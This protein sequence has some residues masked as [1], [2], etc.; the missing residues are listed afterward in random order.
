[1]SDNSPESRDL[2]PKIDFSRKIDRGGPG[3]PVKEPPAIPLIPIAAPESSKRDTSRIPLEKA[4]TMAGEATAS[5]ATKVGLAPRTI[6]IAPGTVS[7]VRVQNPLAA[8][9]PSEEKRK[10]SRVSLESAVELSPEAA[11]GP[12]TIRLKRPAEAAGKIVPT[13]IR[14]AS[15]SE[16]LS[17]TA[18]I[19]EPPEAAGSGGAEASTVTQKKTIKVKRPVTRTTIRAAVQKEQPA[20]ISPES[21]RVVAPVIVEARTGPFFPILAMVALLVMGV[22]VYLQSAEAF[23][24]DF[25]LTQYSYAKGGPDLQWPGKMTF[26][27]Q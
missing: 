3:V 4:T 24:P 20:G 13:V 18:Q 27:Q 19:E 9:L 22:L 7:T 10:T 14:S 21:I 5:G 1:M 25:C 15:G 16:A 23:G 26:G 17:A 12:K 6:R 8:G 2:P 11:A